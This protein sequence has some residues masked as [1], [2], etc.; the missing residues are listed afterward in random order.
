MLST[1]RAQQPESRAEPVTNPDARRHQTKE[2]SKEL[3]T[4]KVKGSEET[5]NYA[6]TRLNI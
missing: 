3:L 4:S 5:L 1:L 2:V 6:F